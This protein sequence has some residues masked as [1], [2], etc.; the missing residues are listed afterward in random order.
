MPES[1]LQERRDEYYAEA[2]TNHSRLQQPPAPAPFSDAQSR[3]DPDARGLPSRSQWTG[4]KYDLR[5]F[6]VDFSQ[7]GVRP[8]SPPFYIDLIYKPSDS[9]PLGLALESKQLIPC[10][11]GVLSAAQ[12]AIDESRIRGF[13]IVLP[14]APEKIKNTPAFAFPSFLFS[15]QC[16]INETRDRGFFPE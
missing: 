16:K 11:F 4:R 7:Q 3:S 14:G 9:V 1:K 15:R 5:A 10:R 6:P 2:A 8:E 12:G 13:L